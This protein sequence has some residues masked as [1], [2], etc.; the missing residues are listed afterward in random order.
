LREALGFPV[1]PRFSVS[2]DPEA[3]ATSP[4]VSVVDKLA[5][6]N[7]L[8]AW[9]R[10]PVP[11]YL[12][13]E[14]ILGEEIHRA[15]RRET[16]DRQGIVSHISGRFDRPSPRP[17]SRILSEAEIAAAPVPAGPHIIQRLQ[18]GVAPALALLTGMQLEIFTLLADGRL[19]AAE[20]AARLG[21]AEDRLSRLLYALVVSELLELREGLFANGAETAAF[22]VKGRGKP[23]KCRAILGTTKSC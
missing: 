11:E 14:A 20:M 10:P 1:A 22:L 9:P 6:R 2:A 7:M 15:L 3:A 12:L 16:S 19:T 18:A 4:I 17:S 23:W 13:L 8:K 5:K 21:V